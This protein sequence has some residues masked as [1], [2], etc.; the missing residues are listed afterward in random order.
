MS[1][2]LTIRRNFGPLDRIALTDKTIMRDVGLLARERIVK[3]TRKGQ[4]VDGSPFRPYTQAYAK[5]KREATGSSAPVN[6]TVSGG[7]LN[8]LTITE[9]TENSVTLG[10][11]S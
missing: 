7:M 3:R 4:S 1:M 5:V 10:F 11:T 6:L 9:V 8:A 2:S